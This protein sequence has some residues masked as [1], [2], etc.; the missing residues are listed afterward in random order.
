MSLMMGKL[1]GNEVGKLVFSYWFGSLWNRLST[2]EVEK[3][4]L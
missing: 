2:I 3:Q 4:I 1:G